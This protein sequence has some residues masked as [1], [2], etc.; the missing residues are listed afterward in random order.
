MSE[1]DGSIVF[2]RACDE[3]K[4][5]VTPLIVRCVR[6]VH[7]DVF[8]AL[9]VWDPARHR[10]APMYDA[11]WR[12]QRKSKRADGVEV[13]KVEANEAA[14]R[15]LKTALDLPSEAPGW[16]CCH[17]W[18]YDDDSFQTAGSWTHD[19]RYYTCVA[20]IVLLPT[21]LKALTDA[22]PRIKTL[23]RTCAFHLYGFAPAGEGEELLSVRSG[24]IPTGYPVEWPDSGPNRLPPGTIPT[25]P[26]D[27]RRVLKAAEKRR[28]QIVEE[29]VRHGSGELPMYPADQVRAVLKHWNVAIA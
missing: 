16:T 1:F 23:L 7:P 19:P 4:V 12:M 28:R 24:A 18:G 26:A 15:W 13:L 11:K 25:M 29:L 27:L 14:N 3:L 10:K 2:Q 6:W 22:V 8:H 21:P 5:D 17:L 20:N 9:P